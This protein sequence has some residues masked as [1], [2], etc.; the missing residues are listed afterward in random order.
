MNKVESYFT[1]SDSVYISDIADINLFDSAIVLSE[2]ERN[3]VLILGNE[4]SI[5]TI[6]GRFGDGPN[7]FSDIGIIAPSD[8]G[9]YVH[10]PG[11]SVLRLYNQEFELIR[12]IRINTSGE[13]IYNLSSFKNKIYYSTSHDTVEAPIVEFDLID[14]TFRYHGEFLSEIENKWQRRIRSEG[15]I[16]KV[17]GSFV[18][19][20]PTEPQIRLL[21]NNFELLSVLDLTDL[22]LLKNSILRS[23]DIYL[24]NNSTILMLFADV[25]CLDQSIYLATYQDF[26]VDDYNSGIRFKRLLN[27]VIRI[28]YD[29]IKEEMEIGRIIDLSN[30][31]G[32]YEQILPISNERMFAFDALT[33][34]LHEFAFQD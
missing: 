23:E 16:F 22:D 13:Y 31:G 29:S 8:E 20:F 4:L 21:D 1:E 33:N 11:H 2:R 30:G 28:D 7:E 34:E 6:V 9:I 19:V 10:D 27:K 14:E 25:F 15:Y 17:G 3:R 5:D 32:W 18:Q 24:N 26:R 12:S